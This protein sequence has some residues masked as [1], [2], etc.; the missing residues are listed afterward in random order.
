MTVV[1]QLRSATVENV[2][3]ALEIWIK[4]HH[5]VVTIPL[6]RKLEMTIQFNVMRTIISSV[7]RDVVQKFLALQMQS[8]AV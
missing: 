1:D 7:P 6:V 5:N 2:K 8:Q 3:S 4:F